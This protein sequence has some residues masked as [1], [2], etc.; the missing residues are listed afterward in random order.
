MKI[1][2]RWTLSALIGLSYLQ[3]VQ[4]EREVSVERFADI[5]FAKTLQ[6]PASV[7]NLQLANIAAEASGRIIYFPALVGDEV[8]KGQVIIKL[9]CTTAKINKTRIEA[10]IKQLM[11]KRK[12]TKQQLERANRLSRSSSIS[13]EELELRETQLV[14]D[15]AGIEEQQALLAAARQSVNYCQIKAPFTGLILEK[16]TSIGSYSTPG[17]TQ[18]KLLKA[19]AVEVRLEIPAAEIPLLTRAKILVY[20]TSGSLYKL[21]IRKILPV[22]DSNSKQ[23][24]VHLTITS[25]D[26]PPGGSYGLV[27]FD[28]LK[29]FIPAHYIQKRKNSF[30]V[31]TSHNGKA[32]FKVLPDAQEGQSVESDLP[33]DTLIISDQLQL[34][35]D[36]EKIT[37]KP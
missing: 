23:Q 1:I 10:V 6:Y 8:K 21:K 17:A 29:H 3:S 30:G 20:E 15:N 18:F 7:I 11:A 5:A 13:R 32:T 26:L 36:N 37:I 12:S 25:A 22:V 19:D 9:D 31:F 16:I 27:K 4:A 2:I 35:N 28:T 34:I 24:I 33:A 14:A